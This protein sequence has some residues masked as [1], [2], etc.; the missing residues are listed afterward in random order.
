M[1]RSFL[2]SVYHIPPSPRRAK[3]VNWR[4]WGWTLS[5][6][7]DTK[8][9][10]K[11]INNLCQPAWS[12]ELDW[13]DGWYGH[14]NKIQGYKLNSHFEATD[15][16]GLVCDICI[17]ESS[18]ASDLGKSQLLPSP[19]THW[20]GTEQSQIRTQTQYQ[21]LIAETITRISPRK[22]A[23]ITRFKISTP[24]IKLEINYKDFHF[25]EE[26]WP[27]LNEQSGKLLIRLSLY[28]LPFKI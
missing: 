17:W 15:V 10:A 23:A 25:P 4:L 8:P 5:T 21:L 18:L 9:K 2:K 22:I 12:L 16:V 27:C 7:R 6:L 28:K 14:R 24:N 19:H 11:N 1:I 20:A 26:I 3:E 13:L